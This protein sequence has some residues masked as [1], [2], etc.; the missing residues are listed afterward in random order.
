MSPW[1]EGPT[2]TDI[3]TGTG[4]APGDGGTGSTGGSD[5]PAAGGARDGLA[6][7][8]GTAEVWRV[9]GPGAPHPWGHPLPAATATTEPNPHGLVT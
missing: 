9:P 3:T 6:G 1:K 4:T 2:G 5:A 7:A 8:G